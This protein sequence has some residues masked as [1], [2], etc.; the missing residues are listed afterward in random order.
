MRIDVHAYIGKWPYW[1]VPQAE[2]EQ[3]IAVMDKATIDT[4]IIVP[5]RSLFVNWCDGNA[6]ATKAEIRFPKD[7]YPFPASVHRN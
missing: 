6:E 5:H 3:V 1:P 4:A 7:L 2:A